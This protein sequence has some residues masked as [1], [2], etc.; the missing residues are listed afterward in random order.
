MPEIK[1]DFS[2]LS[3]AVKHTM[4]LPGV[5]TSARR[6]A[7]KS[8]GWMVQQNLRNHIEYGGTGWPALHP[9]TQ[10]FRHK[11]GARGRWTKRRNHPGPLFWLGKFARYRTMD[12]G[13][14]VHVDFGKSRKGQKGTINYGL[15]EVVARAE[16]GDVVAV[17]PKMRRFLGATRRKRPKDQEPGRTFFPLKAETTRIRIQKRPIF[18][19]VWTKVAPDIP[20]WF[21]K[22]FVSALDRRLAGVYGEGKPNDRV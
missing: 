5:F 1:A 3:D 19:P 9:L 8:V 17:T 12:H 18:G 4:N 15:M 13:D 10:A 22:K 6:S 2:Q 7:I 11:F 14:T 16:E 21:E 20:V